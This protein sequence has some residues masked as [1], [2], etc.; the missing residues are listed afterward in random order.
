MR[1]TQLI[2]DTLAAFAPWPC[3]ALSLPEQF[4]RIARKEVDGELTMTT[5]F[6]A[7]ENFGQLRVVH[8]FS[9]K[10]NVL[11]LFFFPGQAQPLPVYCL[12]LVVFGN[13]PIVGLLDAVCLM[14]MPC[15]DD[16]RAFMAAAH[17]QHP[18]LLQADDTPEWFEACRSGQDFFIRPRGD[19]DMETL[20]ALHLRLLARDFIPL[21]KRTQPLNAQQADKHQ[22]LLQGYKHHHRTNAPG[23]KLMNRSFGEQWTADY[24]SFLFQ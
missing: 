12:E 5:Q 10:I 13:Q 4:S 8:I 19:G 3:Q 21:L 15:T 20:A 1:F 16:V 18:D 2:T 14:P 24:M 22:Q 7:I 23:L 9:P 17:Q 6:W 11:T